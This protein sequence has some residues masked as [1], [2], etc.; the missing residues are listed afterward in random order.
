MNYAQLRA[1]HAVASEGSYTRAADV[2]NVTQPTLST[3]VASLEA[4]YDVKLFQ[5][6]GR[7]IALTQIGKRLLNVTQ[8]FFAVEN[9][10]RQILQTSRG[11][12]SGELRVYADAPYLVVPL[13]ATFNSLYPGIQFSLS[14]GNSTQILQSLFDRRCDVV[15]MPDIPSERRLHSIALKREEVVAFVAVDHPLASRDNITLEELARHRIILREEG[16]TT[17]KLLEEALDAREIHLSDS[18]T[19]GTREAVREVVASGLGIG[20]IFVDE[21]GS[22][23]RLKPLPISNATPE[24]TEYVACL[25]EQKD[26]PLIKA[27]FELLQA[28]ATGE[29]PGKH[30]AKS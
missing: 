29:D 2:M 5:R 3:Q 12:M 6:Q 26:A 4:H 28:A 8:R 18:L 1:F 22:D 9:E 21:I 14:F 10:A 15:V 30:I 7:G 24:T 17:R 20:V 25:A 16:S 11:L 27:F 13:L 23:T 19:V